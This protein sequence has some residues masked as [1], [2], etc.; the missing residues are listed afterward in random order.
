MSQKVN[1]ILLT[2]VLVLVILVVIVG[3]LLGGKVINKLK[4][5]RE[6]KSLAEKNI[7]SEDFNNIKAVS[8]GQ[9]QDVEIAIKEFYKD[10]SIYKKEFMDKLKDEKIKNMLSIQNY[11]NDGPEFTQSLEYIKSSKEEFNKISDNITT[12]LT[13]ENIMSR[14]ENKNLDNYY[15]QLYRNYFFS[16]DK[17]IEN[18]QTTYQDV[19]DAKTLNNNLYN[20]ETKILTFLS[21]NKE[22][23]EI[24]DNKLTFNSA[25]L[26]EEY[27]K[28][29]SN[30]YGE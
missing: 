10:Y 12:I 1:K 25:N 30:L 2:I 15:I 4:L 29:K 24:L 7:D 16:E 17:L 18:L 21:E 27:N 5:D 23:W 22:S 26:S 28:L 6:I 20:N 19:Q 8:S 11:Q 3:I 13:E 14:I 9:Y